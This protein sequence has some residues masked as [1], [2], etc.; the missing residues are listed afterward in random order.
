[1]RPDARHAA[2][3]APDPSPD[4]IARADGGTCPDGYPY[5]LTAEGYAD[6]AAVL[7]RLDA[8]EAARD[9]CAGS[10]RACQADLDAVPE[11]VTCECDERVEYRTPGWVPW[12][13]AVLGV[14]AVGGLA[15]AAAMGAR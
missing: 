3:V 4:H 13:V 1:M 12:V 15:A 8:A 7:D 11:S 9:A 2:A 10:L 5:C 6:I 14:V